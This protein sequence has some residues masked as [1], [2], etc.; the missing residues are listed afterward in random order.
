MPDKEVVR[1]ILKLNEDIRRL[2]LWKDKIDFVDT[3]MKS[4]IKGLI[5]VGLVY[6]YFT[7]DNLLMLLFIGVA[8]LILGVWRDK[9]GIKG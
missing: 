5:I 6:S 9:D 1:E 3:I 4:I 8:V 2:K 7:K